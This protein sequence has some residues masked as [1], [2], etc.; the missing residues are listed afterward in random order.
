MTIPR[1]APDPK[2]LPGLEI[3]EELPTALY[4]LYAADDKLLRVGITW[5]LKVRLAEYKASESWWPEV[6]RKT[7][8]LHATRASAEDAE[9]TAI[10][11]QRPLHNAKGSGRLRAC[12]SVPTVAPAVSGE[13]VAELVLSGMHPTPMRLA[14]LELLG[15]GTQDALKAMGV[16]RTNRYR[17]ISKRAEGMRQVG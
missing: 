1:E 7:V 8:E 5:N 3:G 15:L 11:E 9:R 13:A 10:R 16:A 17:V 6:A 12:P 2:P 4:R 14:I